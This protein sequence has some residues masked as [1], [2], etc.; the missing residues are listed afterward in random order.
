MAANKKVCK[1]NVH[2]CLSVINFDQL[3]IFYITG[4]KK[5]SWEQTMIKGFFLEK[6]ASRESILP[7]F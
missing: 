7:I 4:I 2:V 3:I 1:K 6:A 5:Q